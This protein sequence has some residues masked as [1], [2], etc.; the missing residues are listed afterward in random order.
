MRRFYITSDGDED[1]APDGDYCLYADH[2]AEVEAL[3]KAR[4][5]DHE[6]AWMNG[7]AALRAKA[8]LQRY[9]E[10]LKK[11]SNVHHPTDRQGLCSCDA[12]ETARALLTEP[13]DTP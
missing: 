1:D 11:L 6:Q 13:K 3:T 2:L 5:R 9:R 4:D 8:E 10:A 12:H 7:A